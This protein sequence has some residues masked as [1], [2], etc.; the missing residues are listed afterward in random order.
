MQEEVDDISAVYHCPWLMLVSTKM[1]VNLQVS[2]MAQLI[3]L[4]GIPSYS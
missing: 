3:H 2:E 1:E 4:A